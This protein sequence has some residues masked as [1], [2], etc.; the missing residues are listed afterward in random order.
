MK[1]KKILLSILFV[2]VLIIAGYFKVSKEMKPATD[3]FNKNMAALDIKSRDVT[4]VSDIKILDTT[5]QLYALDKEKL[6][7]KKDETDIIAI[8]VMG[9]PIQS[10]HT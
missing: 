3:K 10:K 9:K 4:R 1:S 7:T 2:L 8:L 6:P 5:I